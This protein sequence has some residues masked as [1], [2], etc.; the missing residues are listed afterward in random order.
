MKSAR[1]SV[2][3]QRDST[4]MSGSAQNKYRASDITSAK[5]QNEETEVRSPTHRR[6]DSIRCERESAAS[7]SKE[8]TTAL[9]VANSSQA[10]WSGVGTHQDIVFWAFPY[11]DVEA[12]PGLRRR[13]REGAH[14]LSWHAHIGTPRRVTVLHDDG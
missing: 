2:A 8:V 13:Q 1:T 9:T 4:S 6:S 14:P 11:P 7:S 12:T 5:E 10:S 3:L